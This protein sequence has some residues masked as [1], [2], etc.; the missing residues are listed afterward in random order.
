MVTSMT[1]A[2]TAKTASL[3]IRWDKRTFQGKSL[4]SVSSPRR[5]LRSKRFTLPLVR[6]LLR[7]KPL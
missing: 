2:G 6:F 3:R 4:R 5:R 1:T 7:P